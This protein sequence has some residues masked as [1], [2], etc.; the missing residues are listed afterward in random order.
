[1][2]A[3]IKGMYRWKALLIQHTERESRE[4]RWRASRQLYTPDIEKPIKF[5]LKRDRLHGTRRV[6][7]CLT[8]CVALALPHIYIYL[9]RWAYVS[10][11]SLRRQTGNCSGLLQDKILAGLWSTR[12]Y[13]LISSKKEGENEMTQHARLILFQHNS[14]AVYSDMLNTIKKEKIAAVGFSYIFPSA[15][16]H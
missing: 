10:Q 11:F 16:G 8:V 6:V 3:F 4:N 15:V 2:L 5:A 9:I 12:Y 1:M 14:R 7:G 13:F